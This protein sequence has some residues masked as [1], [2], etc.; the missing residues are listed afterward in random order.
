MSRTTLGQRLPEIRVP[1]PGPASRALA[2][3]LR[4]V[5]SRNVTQVTTTWPVFWDEAR[6]AN[7]RDAD[8]NVYLDLTGAFGVAL[9]GHAHPAVVEA[10][11]AQA[12]RLIHGM[13]DVHPPSLKV[14]LLE[15]LGALAPWD[16]A[17]VVLSST[18]SEAVETA[19]KTVLVATGRPGILAFEGGY[20]GLTLGAL[21]ATARARFRD[22]FLSR[23]YRGV[24]FAPFPDPVR[25][26]AGAASR[27][28]ARV[29]EILA[30]GAP[31]PDGSSHP[32]GA[33]LVEPVQGR[34]G[35]RV[36]PD[37]FMGRLSD[38]AAGA[39]A[40]VVADEVFTGVGRC[41]TFLASTRVGLRPDLVCLGKALGGGLPLS[42]C[43]GS[44]RVMDAWPKSDG[45]ALHTSTFLGHPLACA[46]A[47]AVLDAVEAEGVAG[48]ARSLG[49]RLVGELRR[50]LRGVE[51]VAD[52][53]GLGLLMGIELARK[54]G[55]DPSTGAAARAALAALAEGV[56]VLPSGEHGHVLELTPPVD[57]TE[58]QL[59][60][61]VEVVAR[62]V[63]GA[64]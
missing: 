2:R 28:L 59:T 36:A 35:S 1:P 4:R 30:H 63:R 21:A 46:A 23:L 57:L 39:G 52:V 7:V 56:L 6:G 54:P 58:A 3:R 43:L 17:R 27:A 22:P 32:I 5:E 42:A 64:A 60:H 51:G 11:R 53:R 18:G 31:T 19:L 50:A 61:G 34:G 49:D 24:A 40:L 14:E 13:G 25:D 16:E 29:E 55:L 33:V 41:G 9:L 10:V 8:G 62:A 12:E 26:G 38:L 37:G 48:R 44:A 15:R 20:H 45:E 47:L